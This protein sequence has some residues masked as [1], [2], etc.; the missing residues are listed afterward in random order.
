MLSRKE[1]IYWDS[2]VYISWITNDRT[3]NQNE[4]AAVYESAKKIERGQIILLGSSVIE[5]EVRL[6]TKDGIEK[7]KQLLKRR[8]VDIKDADRRVTSLAGYISDY[9]ID[10][11]RK[12][13]GPRL[14]PLD[15]IH[16]ATAIHYK[17]DA[18]YTYDDH[19]FP[20]S[21]NVA[22]HNLII[23]KPPESPQLTLPPV[24]PIKR[25]TSD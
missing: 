5:Q 25:D 23:C 20:L 7:F 9:H 12:G 16:L 18:F 13:K 4:M 21:G 15:A 1:I 3:K 2:C 6:R 14:R 17:A 24:P 22:G 11:N 8:N 10:L 19:L